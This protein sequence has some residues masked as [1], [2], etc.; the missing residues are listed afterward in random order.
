MLHTKQAVLIAWMEAIRSLGVDPEFV[1]RAR[2]DLTLRWSES[3][4]NREVYMGKQCAKYTNQER[5]TRHKTPKTWRVMSHTHST[6]FV[7]SDKDQCHDAFPQH[8]EIITLP[9]VKQWCIVFRVSLSMLSCRV[10]QRRIFC[11]QSGGH[12]SFEEPGVP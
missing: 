2:L 1:E 7:L 8:N 3:G 9:L 5:N 10:A 6:E 11:R 4:D 12:R